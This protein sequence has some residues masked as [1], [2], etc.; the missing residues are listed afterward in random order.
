[1]NDLVFLV[2]ILGAMALI[3]APAILVNRLL[4]NAE[5]GSLADLLAIPLDSPWPRGV[6]EE[7]PTR[8]RVESLR[9]GTETGRCA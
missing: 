9:L 3:V 7:E 8:W 6:Q 2:Q 5:G 4:G 1:V